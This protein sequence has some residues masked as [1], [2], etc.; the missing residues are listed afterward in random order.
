LDMENLEVNP[1]DLFG[2]YISPNGWLG[3]VNSGQWYQNDY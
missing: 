2:K 1:V 3:A